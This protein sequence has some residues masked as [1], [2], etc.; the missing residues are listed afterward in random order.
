MT[1]SVFIV[2]V[3]G[4]SQNLEREF[5]HSHLGQNAT[6]LGFS[7]L[8]PKVGFGADKIGQFDATESNT[9]KFVT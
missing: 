4:F 8:G 1:H 9:P 3:G 5:V 6:T 7:R 2:Q